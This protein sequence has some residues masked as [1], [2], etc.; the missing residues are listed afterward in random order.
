V[1]A[2]GKRLSPCH[3][4]GGSFAVSGKYPFGKDF[5]GNDLLE[6]VLAI[7]NTRQE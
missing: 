6:F 3:G 5:S 7:I 1:W 2:L 4:L